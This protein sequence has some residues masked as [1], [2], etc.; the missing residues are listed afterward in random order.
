MTAVMERRSDDIRA[1]AMY[2]ERRSEKTRLLQTGP[3]G[4]SDSFSDGDHCPPRSL[5]YHTRPLCVGASLTP[6]LLAQLISRWTR[7]GPQTGRTAECRN[8]STTPRLRR[9]TC[10]I[11]ARASALKTPCARARRACVQCT[12]CASLGSRWTPCTHGAQ[13]EHTRAW[14]VLFMSVR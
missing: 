2:M 6:L 12:W 7:R 5:P 13:L 4:A 10:V 11:R 14:F 9:S 8:G 3:T 1:V